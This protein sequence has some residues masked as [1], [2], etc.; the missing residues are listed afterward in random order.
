[1][2]GAPLDAAAEV[3]YQAERVTGNRRRIRT[4]FNLLL[5]VH[6]VVAA[7]YW[8]ADGL[9]ADPPGFKTAVFLLDV[10]M[11]PLAAGLVALLLYL[12]PRH[13]PRWWPG[14]SA[15]LYALAY[16]LLG[17]AMSINAQRMNGNI[18][19]F[20][21]TMLGNALVV[22]QRVWASAAVIAI[23]AGTLFTG[24]W[25]IQPDPELRSMVITPV[26][27]VSVLAFMLARLNVSS[28]RSELAARLTIERQRAELEVS[29][30]QL[31][32][33]NRDLEQRV[34]AQ[35]DEIVVRATEIEHLNRHLSE[36]VIERS[37][38][39]GTE[40]R[41]GEVTGIGQVGMATRPTTL[42]NDAYVYT[43]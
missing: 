33:L 36:Q 21:V 16:V 31:A 24:V 7:L 27:T 18:N 22:R 41:L 17:A 23:G 2:R 42:R 19:V 25:W 32:E 8:P 20:T 34:R 6:L 5:P 38:R 28:A 12:E 43:P 37:R 30:Q 40:L 13:A 10:A 3:R 26:I 9:H 14:W 1:M 4:A 29:H 35:V 39:S 11:I 15:D